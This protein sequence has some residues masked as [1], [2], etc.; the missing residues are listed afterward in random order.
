M[1]VSWHSQSEDAG[2]WKV[3]VRNVL[4]CGTYRTLECEQQHTGTN[5]NRFGRLERFL[6][7][8]RA[9]TYMV[10]GN[11]TFDQI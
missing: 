7:I 8:V 6:N 10:L 1:R 3:H 2:G 11:H 9:G 4:Q 5:L